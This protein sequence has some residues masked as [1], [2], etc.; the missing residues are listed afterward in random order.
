MK[1]LGLPTYF[2]NTMTVEVNVHVR[3]CGHVNNLI[4]IILHQLVLLVECDET[5]NRINCDRST[6][7][8]H[9]LTN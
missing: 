5:V 6:L 8:G 3:F 7:F 1:A 9:V 2:F 4:M